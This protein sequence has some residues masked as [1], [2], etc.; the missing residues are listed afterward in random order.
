MIVKSLGGVG[1][2]WTF[3]DQQN[4]IVLE[5]DLASLKSEIMSM[6]RFQRQSE[7]LTSYLLSSLIAVDETLS[8]IV[9]QKLNIPTLLCFIPIKRSLWKSLR[10]LSST[11]FSNS[12]MLMTVCPVTLKVVPRSTDGEYYLPRCLLVL[13]FSQLGTDIGWIVQE[14]K[15]WL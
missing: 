11:F 10:K 8:A 9:S 13:T 3:S 4:D 2:V 1:N 12:F 14:P 6:K 7:Q 15:K 5:S